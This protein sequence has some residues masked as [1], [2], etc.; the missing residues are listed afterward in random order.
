[1]KHKVLGALLSV[2]V[3][4]GVIMTTSGVS[5]ANAATAEMA[6]PSDPTPE[7]QEALR[8][9]AAAIWTPELAAGWNM[10]NDVADVLSRATQAILRCSEAFALVPKPP[11]FI[12]GLSYLVK[13]AR[14]LVDYFSAVR[15]NR[16]YRACVV[17][18]A[19][20]Y[21]TEIELASEG[22]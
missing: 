22:I 6:V 7:E 12:P 4:L 3:A 20:N 19:L 5:L 13:Y 21:R 17:T 14:N 18:T 8:S 11:G 9:V 2:V 16:T 1:M 10:N 15:G